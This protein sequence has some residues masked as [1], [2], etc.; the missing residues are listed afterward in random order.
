MLL[1]YC[2]VVVVDSMLLVYCLVVVVDSMLPQ[3]PWM[4]AIAPGCG[5][6]L[7][8]PPVL[9]PLAQPSIQQVKPV[10]LP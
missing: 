3:T 7:V 1:V 5:V 10:C 6:S 9:P 2:L 4:M 8:L